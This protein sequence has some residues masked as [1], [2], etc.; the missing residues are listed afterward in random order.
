MPRPNPGESEQAYVSRFMASA[1]AQKDFPDEKQRAAV[2]YSMFK[3]KKNDLYLCA[4]CGAEMETGRS[5]ER[6]RQCG[7]CGGQAV[8]ATPPT[9]SIR[10]LCPHCRH[11]M[12]PEHD[13]L[14][15][16]AEGCSCTE[17]PAMALSLGN[18][19]DI[20]DLDPA[21]GRMWDEASDAEKR[22]CVGMA[23]L[24]IGIIQFRWIQM[25]DS[26][27]AALK[28][29]VFDVE[30]RNA[31]PS[32]S[33]WK[34]ST[35]YEADGGCKKCGWG[36]PGTGHSSGYHKSDCKTLEKER[37]K[38]EHLQGTER[39]NSTPICSACLSA[40][41]NPTEAN[42]EEA[43]GKIH[44][45]RTADDG[46]GHWE[47]YCGAN[48]CE[49]RNTDT[50]QACASGAF[51]SSYKKHEGACAQCGS[52]SSEGALCAEGRKL[53]DAMEHDH[54]AH[55][56]RNRKE[57]VAEA[58]ARLKL[59]AEKWWDEKGQPDRELALKRAGLPADT[60]AVKLA[61]AALPAASRKAI[62]DAM[63]DGYRHEVNNALSP[64][65]VKA[66]IAEW[67]AFLAK[68]SITPEERQYAEK[69]RKSLAADLEKTNAACQ[70]P[71]N[72]RGGHIEWSG[73]WLRQGV[74]M[75][76]AMK[77]QC[78]CGATVMQERGNPHNDDMKPRENAADPKADQAAMIA[79]KLRDILAAHGSAMIRKRGYS[80]PIT[81]KSAAE[82]GDLSQVTDVDVPQGV[83]NGTGQGPRHKDLFKEWY[84]LDKKQDELTRQLHE[85]E[86]DTGAAGR[87]EDPKRAPLLAELMKV[88]KAIAAIL[89]KDNEERRNARGSELAKKLG[90]AHPKDLPFDQIN[91]HGCNGCDDIR[92]PLNADGYCKQCAAEQG[93][94]VNAKTN[95]EWHAAKDAYYGHYDACEACQRDEGCSTGSKLFV[96]FND[97]QKKAEG[98]NASGFPLSYFKRPE[99]KDR[100]DQV[101][102]EDMEDEDLT[103][104]G[105]KAK[106]EALAEIGGL[107][108]SVS[109]IQHVGADQRQA[110]GEAVYGSR[111]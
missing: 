9:E 103:P 90:V 43:G 85:V 73:E 91:E 69:V 83:S 59:E 27:K 74:N 105:L 56:A 93:A 102:I 16:H 2:A 72:K 106:R 47:A 20:N 46:S 33:Q 36:A 109:G 77:G 48:C 22:R 62:V 75:P 29:K 45:K 81:V 34:D 89:A 3:E 21:I 80:T 13:D 30:N 79:A 71:Q 58:F 66:K 25:P 99:S 14:G 41:P 87:Y 1:E 67:D 96:K 31:E 24:G 6:I 5:S 64:D 98:K 94:F 76:D 8:D 97:E 86:S 101:G 44:L 63:N 32:E 54:V 61:W 12:E 39:R 111:R 100:A 70:H 88:E 19:G 49:N 38:F 18:A 95:H 17:T 51:F 107:D 37:K 57:T 10:N 26:A 68:P 35:D 84:E 42:A 55:E 23:G 104:A 53:Y 40:C 4:E 28:K 11:Q 52:A 65:Q 50:C 7:A 92:A 82:A 78:A 60:E 110:D 15:C 108:N